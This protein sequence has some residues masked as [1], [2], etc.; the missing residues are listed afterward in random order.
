M[1]AKLFSEPQVMNMGFHYTIQFSRRNRINVVGLVDQSTDEWADWYLESHEPA[2][3]REMADAGY[4]LIEI[5][6]LYGFGLEGER[7]EWERARTMTRNAHD[8][9]LKVLGYFQFHS[10]QQEVFF[11]ENPWAKDCIQVDA[12][13]KRIQYRYDRPALCF[14]DERVQKY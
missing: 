13:G 14:S 12:E 9:G 4:T 3:L 6:F 10:V 2:A 8:I 11:L 7:E 1:Q 5:H